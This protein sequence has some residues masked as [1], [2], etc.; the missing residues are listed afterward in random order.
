MSSAGP[1]N[2]Q[3][4]TTGNWKPPR[5][6]ACAL[7]KQR[8]VKCNRSFPCENCV[9]AGAECVQPTSQQRRRRFAERTLLD[10]L[11][12]Y[13]HL[14]R[15]NNVA[16]EPL[17]GSASVSAAAAPHHLEHDGDDGGHR[18]TRS[19]DKEAMCVYGSI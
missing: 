4:Q 6:L 17:H 12:H 16:F 3:T 14:L 18:A 10:R 15:Q 2:N 11:N 5:V 1:S 19:K 8:R 9:R 7:C 13:E